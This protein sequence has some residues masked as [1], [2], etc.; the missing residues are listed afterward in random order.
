MSRLLRVSVA[1]PAE[2]AEEA[3]AAM[4]ELAPAGFEELNTE[5]GVELAAYTDVAGAD[6]IRRRWPAAATRA[7]RPGWEDQWR[8]FHRP[9][10]VG[11]LWI[12]PS[13]EPAPP[14]AVRIEIDPGRAFGTGAHPTTRLC[15]QLLIEVPRG[16]L[17]DVGCGSGVLAIAAARLGFRPVTAVDSD[18]VAVEVARQNAAANAVDLDVRLADATADPLPPADTVVANISGEALALVVPR[19]RASTLIASGYLDEDAST[20]PGFRHER[21]L[22]DAGW[23][24]DLYTRA[25]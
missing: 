24:A 17:L 21:R 6:R 1:V 18:A 11:P 7:V 3:R 19:V 20:R 2:Q 13:W 14:D 22:T 12:G 5:T 25:V 8:D 9:V 23:A 4:L 10:R 16:R 15:L